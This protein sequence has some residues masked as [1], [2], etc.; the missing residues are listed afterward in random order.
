MKNQ[1]EI[2][3]SYIEKIEQENKDLKAKVRNRPKFILFETDW[4]RYNGPGV[5]ALVLMLP[6]VVGLVSLVWASVVYR[7]NT[8]QFYVSSLGNEFCV[9]QKYDWAE[10]DR[11]ECWKTSDKAYDKAAEHRKEWKRLESLNNE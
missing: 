5:I 6:I 2:V 9:Y 4:W 3:S 10:D 8:G 7:E 11:I 1:D